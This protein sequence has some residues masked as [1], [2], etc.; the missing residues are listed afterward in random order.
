MVLLEAYLSHSARERFK[1]PPHFVFIEANLSFAQH[2]R[3]EIDA[4]PDL[5]GAPVDLIQALR[6]VRW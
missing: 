5:A 4:I 1:A 3:W 2:L 6:V